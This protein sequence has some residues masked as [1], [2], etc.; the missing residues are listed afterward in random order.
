MDWFW[1]VQR[2][3]NVDVQLQIYAYMFIKFL[4]INPIVVCKIYLN[5]MLR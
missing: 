2:V 1:N 3:H 5:V 4:L